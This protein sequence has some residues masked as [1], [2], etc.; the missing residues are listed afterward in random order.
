MLDENELR[1]KLH[2]K[3]RKPWKAGGE[4]EERLRFVVGRF[5]PAKG[6]WGKV[7]D[8]MKNER[9]TAAYSVRWSQIEAR[10]KVET[11]NRRHTVEQDGAEVDEMYDPKKHGDSRP[12]EEWENA[13]L[14]CP[15]PLKHR[16]NGRLQLQSGGR[17]AVDWKELI[18]RLGGRR[19]Q[20]SIQAQLEKMKT[21]QEKKAEEEQ[22]RRENEIRIQTKYDEIEDEL[23][24][25]E[26]AAGPSFTVAADSSFA[27]TSSQPYKPC[28]NGD[29][30]VKFE[31]DD[32]DED[33]EVIVVKNSQDK[34][35]A[36]ATSGDSFSS[37]TFG[38]STRFTYFPSQSGG[39]KPY[40]R[41]PGGASGGRSASPIL[42]SSLNHSPAP[43]STAAATVPKKKPSSAKTAI[44]SSTKTA[45]SS[46]QPRYGAGAFSGPSPFG[47]PSSFASQSPFDTSSRRD[48]RNTGSTTVSSAP[49]NSNSLNPT[50]PTASS[51][52]SPRLTTSK[53]PP[54]SS[55]TNGTNELARLSQENQELKVQNGTLAKEKEAEAREKAELVARLD[56]MEALL[57]KLAGGSGAG[58]G[59]A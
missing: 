5:K 44:S 11:A 58:A 8:L 34:G 56:R 38:S 32:G 2:P 27:G 43:A 30:R 49:R 41:P 9:R 28:S 29:K 42:L 24:A 3:H 37:S 26:K 21:P 53:Q 47:G 36:R 59:G 19:T 39:S 57:M 54:S 48:A 15:L 16:K 17:R 52:S 46:S 10:E 14:R 40:A 55:E 50:V 7:A 12:W 25:R 51:S 18:S 23:A 20:M 22:E 31:V 35:K 33:D 45:S 6:G 4:E 13:V 1:H